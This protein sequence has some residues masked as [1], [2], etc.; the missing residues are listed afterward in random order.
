ML[1]VLPSKQVIALIERGQP[2]LHASFRRRFYRLCCKLGTLRE[3]PKRHRNV[4]AGTHALDERPQKRRPRIGTGNMVEEP[5]A[6]RHIDRRRFDCALNR[7]VYQRVCDIKLLEGNVVG[8]AREPVARKLLAI[9]HREVGYRR[10]GQRLLQKAKEATVAARHI[11][12]TQRIARNLAGGES[13]AFGKRA[14]GG[15]RSTRIRRRLSADLH[16][17]EAAPPT[18]PRSAAGRRERRG[19][20]AVESRGYVAQFSGGFSIHKS[21]RALYRFATQ[22]AVRSGPAIR[23]RAPGPHSVQCRLCRKPSKPYCQ[24]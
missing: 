20:L 14:P 19:V 12:H 22:R 4:P 3:L 18:R 8:V 23:Q 17:V 5:E 15:S 1:P 21:S 9:V 16:L 2:I 7:T 24:P 6:H 13:G 11:E 10:T